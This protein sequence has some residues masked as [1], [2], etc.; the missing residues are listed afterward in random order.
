MICIVCR[1]AYTTQS[2]TSI[3]FER[4]EFRAMV[5]KIPAQVCPACG[6]SYL[7]E[8]IAEELL[9]RVQDIMAE[10]EMDVVLEYR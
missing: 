10:G 3:Q 7:E 4:D 2:L 6:E 1:E 5:K 8:G 9:K